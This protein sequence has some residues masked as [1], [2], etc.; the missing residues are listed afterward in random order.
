MRPEET[1]YRSSDG[2]PLPMC[3]W[4]PEKPRAAL[5]YLHGIQS[6]SGWYEAS[7]RRL[8]SAGVAVYQIERRGSGTD[9]A[10]E[11]GHVD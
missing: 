7:S 3:V 2:T 1:T 10:H 9:S 4:R 6:H 8:A 11:R 5:V